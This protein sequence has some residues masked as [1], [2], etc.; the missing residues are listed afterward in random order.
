MSRPAQ[1]HHRCGTTCGIRLGPGPPAVRGAVPVLPLA[2]PPFPGRPPPGRILL[3]RPLAGSGLRVLAVAERRLGAGE[4]E[5]DALE[6]E[7][8]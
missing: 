1:Q 2:G 6:R 5:S 7:L 8:E 4:Q 3:R